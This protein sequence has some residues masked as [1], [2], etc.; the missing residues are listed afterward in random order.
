M[1]YQHTEDMI[2]DHERVVGD[3]GMAGVSIDSVE[4]MKILFDG[5]PLGKFHFS[6]N[7]MNG[8]VHPT[9]AI[10]YKLLLNSR[11]HLGLN[12]SL[13]REGTA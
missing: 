11:R 12:L 8:A 3:V 9:M 2:L 1:T 6:L 5:I 7:D 4:D 13:V 10:I